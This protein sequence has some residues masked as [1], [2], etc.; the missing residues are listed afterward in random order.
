MQR[1]SKEELYE[2]NPR[3]R[4]AGVIPYAIVNGRAYWLM[5]L[6]TYQ[7]FQDMKIVWSDF[8]GGCRLGLGEL[9]LNCLLRETDEESSGVLTDVIQNGIINGNPL[10][11]RSFSRRGFP[12]G[13]FVLVEIPY[14]EY[15]RDFIP[16]EEISALVWL[17]DD[18][19]L[20]PE[21]DIMKFHEPIRGFIEEFR[22]GGLQ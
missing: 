2:F 15:W 19:I 4:R 8:G 6:N 12:T 13:Y 21:V 16:N 5:G 17:P 14:A 22:H 3:G 10:V 1:V 7:E 20:N 11:W 9:P 18:E